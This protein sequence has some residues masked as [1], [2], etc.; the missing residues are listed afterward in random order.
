MKEFIVEVDGRGYCKG[1]D[2]MLEFSTTSP[3][4]NIVFQAYVLKDHRQVTK[5]EKKKHPKP[6][7]AKLW[8]NGFYLC[9]SQYNEKWAEDATYFVPVDFEFTST[10]KELTDEDACRRVE[11]IGWNDGHKSQC[12]KGT[13]IYAGKGRYIIDTYNNGVVTFDNCELT[14]EESDE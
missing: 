3:H 7:C 6:E 11:V 14:K 12:R 13:L 10:K 8:N 4:S 9:D 2:D 1:L 5:E